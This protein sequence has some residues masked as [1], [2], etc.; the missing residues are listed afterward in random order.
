MILIALT[1]PDDIFMAQRSEFRPLLKYFVKSVI[2][3]SFSLRIGVSY[4]MENGKVYA[5]F[6]YSFLLL[7]FVPSQIVQFL[8]IASKI[9]EDSK[10]K[11]E[12][13]INNSSIF[14]IQI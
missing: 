8:S 2:H 11:Y 9:V 1:S 7:Y 10:N 4:G 12:K 14:Q 5:V 13:Q 3:C 6:L